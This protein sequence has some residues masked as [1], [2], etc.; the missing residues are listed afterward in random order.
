MSFAPW[1]ASHRAPAETPYRAATHH[2]LRRLVGAAFSPNVVTGLAARI[3]EITQLTRKIDEATAELLAYLHEHCADRRAHP[4]QDLI[5]TLTTTEVNGQ[6][7][8]DEEVVNFSFV[9]LQE[10]RSLVES[11]LKE[12]LRQRTPFT[13]VGRVTM[14]ETELSGH[15]IPADAFSP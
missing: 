12:V 6:R 14:A 15:V 11:A 9:L 7:L 5:S 13:Q 4:G 1:V 3:A 8:T 2:Q 10:D